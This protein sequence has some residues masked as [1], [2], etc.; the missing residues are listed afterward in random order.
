[1]RR[2][3]AAQT[4]AFETERTKLAE[5]LEATQNRERGLLTHSRVGAPSPRLRLRQRITL[6]GLER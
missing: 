1:M 2:E 3:L 6:R 5:Q 4:A